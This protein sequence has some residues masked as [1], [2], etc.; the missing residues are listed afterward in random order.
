MKS[1]VSLAFSQVLETIEMVAGLCLAAFFALGGVVYIVMDEHL[2][3]IIFAWVLCAIGI[4]LFFAGRKR[5]KMRRKFQEYVMHLSA[6]PSRSLDNLASV[7]NTSVDVVKRNLQYMIDK[8][9]FKSASINEQSH[10]LVLP[11]VVPKTKRQSN[12]P[13]QQPEWIAYTCPCCGAMN[14]VEKG[15]ASEC[16]FCGSPLPK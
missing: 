15:T 2:G 10:Q 9:F 7:T 13:Q 5:A 1:K 6:D 14:R 12:S 3:I 11:P 16:D 8:K 4:L